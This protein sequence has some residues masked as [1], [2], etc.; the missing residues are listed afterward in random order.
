[1]AK[2]LGTTAATI[3]RLETADMNVS[4]NWLQRFAEIYNVPVAELIPESVT[5]SRIPC[6]G[7]IDRN[8]ALSAQQDLVH[9]DIALDARAKDPIAIRIAEDMGNYC[10]G[11]IVI[12]DRIQGTE[13]KRAVG[14]DCFVAFDGEKGGFGR[15]ISSGNGTFLL[16]P[17]EPGHD[18][19]SLA[20][21]GWVAPVVMLIRYL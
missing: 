21:P 16:V 8:G 19:Y 4:M 9:E 7:K 1:M 10:A 18:A 3:S 5:P 20:A 11:D 15:F 17:P 13:L 6:V 14:K 12:A 2:M